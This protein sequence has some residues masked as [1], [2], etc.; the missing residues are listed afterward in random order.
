MNGLNIEEDAIKKKR[1]FLL[2]SD[3]RFFCVIK[4]GSKGVFGLTLC[5]AGEAVAASLWEFVGNVES[6]PYL[7]I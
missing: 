5:L 4:K 7:V 3:S 1:S 6:R 2:L